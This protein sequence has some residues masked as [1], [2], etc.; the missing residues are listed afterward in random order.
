MGRSVRAARMFAAALVAVGV[1]AG[2]GLTTPAFAGAAA[3]TG[4]EFGLMPVSVAHPPSLT[5]PSV[6]CSV[7]NAAEHAER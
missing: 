1:G 6:T 5:N 4:F 7:R 3:S 2:L